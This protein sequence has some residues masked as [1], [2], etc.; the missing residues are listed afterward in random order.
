MDGDEERRADGERDQHGRRDV[1][2]L[3]QLDLHH[4]DHGKSGQQRRRLA[5]RLQLGPAQLQLPPGQVVGRVVLIALLGHCAECGTS[6]IVRAANTGPVPGH[7]RLLQTGSD[8]VVQRTVARR[9]MTVTVV[10]AGAVT[11]P[12]DSASGTR[13]HRGQVV[14]TAEQVL[15]AVVQ[16]RGAVEIV[17][18]VAAA[19]DEV[20]VVQVLGLKLMAVAGGSVG[21]LR[22]D[23]RASAA[24]Q[25]GCAEGFRVT[26]GCRAQRCRK[27]G[28]DSG[29][30]SAPHGHGTISLF[31][32]AL[33]VGAGVQHGL[34]D[35]GVCRRLAAGG[36]SGLGSARRSSSGWAFWRVCC[37][38]CR[39]RGLRD[40]FL[41][42]RI[43]TLLIAQYRRI[44]TAGSQVPTTC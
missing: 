29:R 10:A 26:E 34:V 40:L 35:L 3:V 39:W 8:G 17:V 9:G 24:R 22:H 37:C 27:Y 42:G 33:A 13:R 11:A 5:G 28:V 20:M 19:G 14:P 6:L 1:R 21:N 44:T 43:A 12:G 32:A 30:A 4:G 25:V 16:G 15:M 36:L 2:L 41:R 23:Q 38:C 18:V 31:P 7:R